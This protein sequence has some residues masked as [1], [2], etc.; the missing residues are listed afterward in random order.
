MPG[1]RGR[2]VVTT[3]FVEELPSHDFCLLVQ[4]SCQ[5]VLIPWVRLTKP[6]R[7]PLLV[8]SKKPW[9]M[10]INIWRGRERVK[11]QVLMVPLN[12]CLDIVHKM[13]TSLPDILLDLIHIYD[14]IHDNM[15]NLAS[16]DKAKPGQM[17][18]Y[19]PHERLGHLSTIQS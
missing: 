5:E 3:L 8:T 18:Q 16:V 11:C 15:D 19:L 13:I 4:K 2:H 12:I 6:V 17:P 10:R 1:T 14:I 9:N 7:I